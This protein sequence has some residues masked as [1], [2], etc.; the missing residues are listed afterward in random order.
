MDELRR[1][2]DFFAESLIRLMATRES[3]KFGRRH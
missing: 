1:R 3:G 2:P